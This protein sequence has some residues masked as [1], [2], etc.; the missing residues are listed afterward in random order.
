[1]AEFGQCYF[2]VIYIRAGTILYIDYQFA[3]WNDSDI[4]QIY[5]DSLSNRFWPYFL[6]A[7]GTMCIRTTCNVTLLASISFKHTT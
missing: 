6:T 3:I 4:L 2:S 7:D 5:R 1:M